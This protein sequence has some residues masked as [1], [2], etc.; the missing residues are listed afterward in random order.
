[1]VR[2][3]LLRAGSMLAWGWLCAYI[4]VCVCVCVCVHLHL[5]VG[6]VWGFGGCWELAQVF[7]GGGVL[8]CRLNAWFPCKHGSGAWTY[9]PEHKSCQRQDWLHTLLSQCVG[10]SSA[11]V[12][13]LP[14]L[15]HNCEWKQLWRSVCRMSSWKAIEYIRR[16]VKITLQLFICSFSLLSFHLFL[17]LLPREWS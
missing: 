7:A 17:S 3:Q 6:E 10:S 15:T 9:A 12:L 11:A 5:G 4:S 13:F 1:M 14:A 16:M 2:E 8:S